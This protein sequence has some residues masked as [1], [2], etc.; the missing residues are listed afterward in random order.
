MST[1]K[2]EDNRDVTRVHDDDPFA[3]RFDPP[4]YGY[5]P[6][7][8]YMRCSYCGSIT[9]TDMLRLLQ[10]P[11]VRYSGSDWKYGWPH[12]FYL[13]TPNGEHLKFYSVHIRDATD[14]QHFEWLEV[15]KPLLGVAFYVD[16]EKRIAYT[17]VSRGYQASGVVQD[18]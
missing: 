2:K 1:T 5:G 14:A 12:K 8:P 9:V 4:R 3:Y 11:G 6:H 10:K 13:T 7:H 18:R 16:P 17:A 15:A